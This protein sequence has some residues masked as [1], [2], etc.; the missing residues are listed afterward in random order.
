MLRERRIAQVSMNLTDYRRTPPSVAFQRVREEAEKLGV[1]VLE[2]EIIGLVPEAA[3]ADTTP[4]A[5]MLSG[6]SA[7]RMLERRLI[8]AGV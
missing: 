6:F 5:L 3:L 1:A 2:S 8:A 4:A 7:D